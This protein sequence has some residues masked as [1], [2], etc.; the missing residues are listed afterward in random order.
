MQVC[1]K[2]WATRKILSFSLIHYELLLGTKNYSI[3]VIQYFRRRLNIGSIILNTECNI[4]I[5]PSDNLSY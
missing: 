4:H 1:E 5:F 3:Q 2:T